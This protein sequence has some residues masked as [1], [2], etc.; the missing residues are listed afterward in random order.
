[1]ANMELFIL[2]VPNFAP[3]SI[4]SAV[5]NLGIILDLFLITNPVDLTSE[6]YLKSIHFISRATSL[7]LPASSV[8]IATSILQ[9]DSGPF[10]TQHPVLF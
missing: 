2:P 7:D 8:T 5:E 4:D 10:S 6:I 3:P 1:M 9:P